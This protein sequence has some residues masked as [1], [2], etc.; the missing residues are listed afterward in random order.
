MPINDA[1]LHHELD[2]MLVDAV[3][4]NTKL[5]QANDEFQRRYDRELYGDEEPEQ[6]SF[7]SNDCFDIVESDMPPLVKLFLGSGDVMKF[8]PRNVGNQEDRQEAEEKSKY[9]DWQIRKQPWSYRVLSGW[10]KN[11]EVLQISPVKYMIEETTEIEEHKKTGLSDDELVAFEESLE[12]ENVKSI[13][14]VREEL[15]EEGAESTV[16]F[17]VEKTRKRVKVEI[18][19]LESF[20][21]SKNA[22]DKNDA[23]VVGDVQAIKRGD[24]LKMGFDR[25]L[26]SQIPL[27]GVQQSQNSSMENIR[28]RDEGNGE[29]NKVTSIWAQEE[30]EI[31]DLY[32]MI[33]YD[34]DGIPERRHIMRSAQG[35]IILVNEAFNHVPYAMISAYQSPNRA[36]GKSRVEVTAP[37][38]EAKTYVQR[39]MHNNIYA[40]NNPRLGINKNV[41][42]D[43]VFD[44]NINGVVRSSANTPIG[45]DITQITIPFIGDAA[46]QVMQ[47]LDQSRAKTTGSQI[48]SQGLD[49]DDFG[50]ETATR[51]QGVQDEGQDKIHLV[52]RNYADGWRELYE[53]V[54]WLD[55]NFQDSATEIS[56]LGKELKVDPRMWA[57]NHNAVPMVGLAIGDDEEVLKNMSALWNVLTQLKSEGSLMVD[58]KKRYNVLSKTIKALGLENVG[59][60]A[61][62]PEQPE[63]LLQAQNEQMVQAIQV[64]Q[65]QLEAMQNPLAESET[66]RAQAKLIE[67]QVKQQSELDKLAEQIRQFNISTAQNQEQFDQTLAKDLTQMEI[68][69]GQDIPGSTV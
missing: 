12:G 66:I 56:V 15:G 65:K 47:F 42:F 23:D 16:V 35:D 52:A 1:T 32:P 2:K 37:T 57:I 55:Q 25:E 34:D 13:D 51:F 63:E 45:N 17:R 9:V 54:A 22:K 30:V 4:N 20:R 68:D 29:E 67:A 60:F 7:V 18:V 59:E 39:G 61:N 10:L 46:I 6:S 64:M 14:L 27:S 21:M 50:K 36:V 24:L 19:N 5:M 3:G 8:D 11:A 43:D 41:N 53:G 58:E 40:V 31:E 48:A 62:D 28:N 44:M 38:A 49:S 33:D 69:S 26:I